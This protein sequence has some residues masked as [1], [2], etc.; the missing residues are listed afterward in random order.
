MGIDVLK[1]QVEPLGYAH[2][3]DHLLTHVIPLV[4]FYTPWK[5]QKN[6]DFLMF[7]GVMEREKWHE[8]C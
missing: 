1:I 4:S 2:G 8:T 3:R 6:S 5:D 7:S